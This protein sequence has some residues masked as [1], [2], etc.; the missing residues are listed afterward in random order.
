MDAIVME[1]LLIDN[2]AWSRLSDPR[3]P[4]P[5]V[6]EVAD[7]AEAGELY[8]CAPFLL[9]AGYS[10]RKATDHEA[11]F[12][13]LFALPW[14][15]IDEAVEREA[16]ESQ[17]QLAR[18]GHHRLRPV[19]LLIAA[20]AHV[21]RLGVLHYDRDFDVIANLTALS[22]SSEWLVMAASL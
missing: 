6:E 18:E 5:R 4:Q 3:V 7:A 19:G 13:E 9:E 2:S 17:R 14:A 1:R 11:L 20:I 10:A 8:V 12:T 22:F 15:G 16:L 21:H